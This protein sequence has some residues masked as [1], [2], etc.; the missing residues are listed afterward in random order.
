MSEFWQVLITK[1]MKVYP[2]LVLSG[3]YGKKQNEENAPFKTDLS[4]QQG[5]MVKEKTRKKKKKDCLAT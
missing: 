3:T 4:D 5:E 2:F 1:L